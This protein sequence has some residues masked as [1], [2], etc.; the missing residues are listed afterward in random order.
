MNKEIGLLLGLGTNA[1]LFGPAAILNALVRVER[2]VQEEEEEQERA[3]QTQY[4]AERAMASEEKFLVLEKHHDIT[5][6][7]KD[8]EAL[9]LE[10]RN[11]HLENRV[12]RLEE[13]IRLQKQIIDNSRRSDKFNDVMK[14]L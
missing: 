8:L 1:L 5:M 9:R 6:R 7:E 10:D 12:K 4:L 2:S 3:M 14:M 13:E 11:K